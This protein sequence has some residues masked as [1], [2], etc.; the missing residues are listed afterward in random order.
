MFSKGP[1]L[2]V[3][4]VCE[5]NSPP[6]NWEVT[7]TAEK[8]WGFVALWAP[9]AAKQPETETES[10]WLRMAGCACGAATVSAVA[11]RPLAS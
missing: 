9:I 7:G 11:R 8:V 1:P 3:V 5:S 2:V 4:V 10:A 6:K